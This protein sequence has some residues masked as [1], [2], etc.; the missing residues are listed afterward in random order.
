VVLDCGS[1]ALGADRAPYATGFGRLLGEPDA[2]IVSL[3][4]H[5][6]VV[7]LGRSHLPPLGTQLDVVPNHVCA[8]VN[9]ADELWVQEAGSLRSWRVSARGLNA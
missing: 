4:E 3:S 5:H 7:D 1:K 9:L 2:R 6:A 8:A